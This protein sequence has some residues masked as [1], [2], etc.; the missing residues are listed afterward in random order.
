VEVPNSDKHWNLLLFT[1]VTV[2]FA[3]LKKVL[4]LINGHMEELFGRLEGDWNNNV[5]LKP[6]V[7][8]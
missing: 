2:N 6:L 8:L 1:I 4:N 3:S 7:G 5:D